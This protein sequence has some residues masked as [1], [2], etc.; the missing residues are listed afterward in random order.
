MARTPDA[1]VDGKTKKQITA[2]IVEAKRS[3]CRGRAS[4]A[5]MGLKASKTAS[6]LPNV[7]VPA[8]KFS[9]AKE[10]DSS[11]ADHT[12]TGRLTL[13]ASAAGGAKVMLQMRANG[14]T[15][16]CNWGN[17][18]EST[19]PFAKRSQNGAILSR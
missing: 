3:R 19:K 11:R 14:A 18:S 6:S 7:K 4:L 1:V 10:R 2:F 17:P 5:L 9:G 8:N 16:V 13:P 15:S 12:Q